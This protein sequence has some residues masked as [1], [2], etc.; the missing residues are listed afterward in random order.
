MCNIVIATSRGRRCR[1]RKKEREAFRQ[2]ALSLRRS[3][4]RTRAPPPLP[5][6]RQ[7]LRVLYLPRILHKN[8]NVA[9][10]GT[11]GTLPAVRRIDFLVNVSRVAKAFA[12]FL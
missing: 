2:A 5:P 12:P 1:R 7:V 4:A 9:R 8:I 10:T 11:F 6:L 3:S